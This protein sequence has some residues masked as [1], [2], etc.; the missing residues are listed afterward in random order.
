MSYKMKE[1]ILIIC[2]G[3]ESCRFE[4]NALMVDKSSDH[5]FDRLLPL[6]I[7]S[8]FVNLKHILPCPG[9]L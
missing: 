9:N 1:S 6:S 4:L 8:S 7:P 3:L 5:L 2:E